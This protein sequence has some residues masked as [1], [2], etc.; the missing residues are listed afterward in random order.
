M[1]QALF[2][3]QDVFDEDDYLYFYKESLTDERTDVEVEALVKYLELNS[4][5][6]ILDLACGYG[7]HTN[8]LAALGHEMVGV[9]LMPGFLSIARQDAENRNVQ[10]DYCQGDMR[11]I[12][13]VEEFDRVMIVFTAFG[14]F[15]DDENLDV[16]KRV[17]R[18]LKPGGLFIVDFLNRDTILRNFCPYYVVEKG[19]DLMIDRMSLDSLTG[20]WNN[21][22]IVIRDGVRKDKFF[23]IRIYNPSE[24]RHLLDRAGLKVVQMYGNWNGSLVS[25]DE[26]RLVTVARK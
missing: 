18:A 9:D 25:M 10:V 15:D 14:Y 26:R 11:Q 19:N 24:M 21:R 6:R 23:S 17:A 3:L 4:P 1:S 13:F 16:L 12:D 22:R 8:R 7:R 5:Q 2:D 20:R